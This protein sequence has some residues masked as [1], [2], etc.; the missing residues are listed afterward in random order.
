MSSGLFVSSICIV[1][2]AGGCCICPCPQ[3]ILSEQVHQCF[4]CVEYR[5]WLRFVET[6]RTPHTLWPIQPPATRTWQSREHLLMRSVEFGREAQGCLEQNLI[7]WHVLFCRF[8]TTKY[9]HLIW[10]TKRHLTLHA[11]KTKVFSHGSGISCEIRIHA[12]KMVD[13]DGWK[14]VA[15]WLL[16]HLWFESMFRYNL[17]NVT[18]TVKCK[19]G[20]KFCWYGPMSTQSLLACEGKKAANPLT[21]IHARI[22]CESMWD[23]VYFKH[24]FSDRDRPLRGG[25]NSHWKSKVSPSPICFIARVLPV[26][27]SL[28]LLRPSRHVR[29]SRSYMNSQAT[30]NNIPKGTCQFWF[31]TEYMSTICRVTCTRFAGKDWRLCWFERVLRHHDHHWNTLCKVQIWH[32][33]CSCTRGTK[34]EI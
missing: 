34:Q 21:N 10:Y 20:S 6:I 14:Q 15:A 23:T 17:R 25:L 28:W 30:N 11:F 9:G 16:Y 29:L 18:S 7:C 5:A 22:S 3:H 33:V 2:A 31:V 12:R 26:T 19:S 8:H 13:C 4:C 32:I 27:P 24:T 1:R